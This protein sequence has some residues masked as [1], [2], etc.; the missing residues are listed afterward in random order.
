MLNHCFLDVRYK[1]IKGVSIFPK[2]S[3]LTNPDRIIFV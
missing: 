3:Y 1:V 2:R